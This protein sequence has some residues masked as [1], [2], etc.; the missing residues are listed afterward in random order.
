MFSGC[1]SAA[2]VRLSNR[3]MRRLLARAGSELCHLAAGGALANRREAVACEPRILALRARSSTGAGTS[4]LPV[5]YLV[6]QAF[7]PDQSARVARLSF[8]SR[9]DESRFPGP[10]RRRPPRDVPAGRR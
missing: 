2:L 6:A 1:S 7:E 10:S 8:G 9:A 4:S 5:L 3:F